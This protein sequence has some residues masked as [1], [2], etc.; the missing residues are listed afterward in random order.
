MS[1]SRPQAEGEAAP[2]PPRHSGELGS[3][4]AS[5]RLL[6]YSDALLS[7][8]ATVMVPSFQNPCRTLL[9]QGAQVS[10]C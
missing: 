3:T 5:H 6:A 9:S 1:A 10:Q 7:I 8:I 4:Q 2:G